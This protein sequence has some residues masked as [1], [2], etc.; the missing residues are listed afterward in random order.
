M[1]SSDPAI[2]PVADFQSNL[3]LL[4]VTSVRAS[5][6]VRERTIQYTHQEIPSSDHEDTFF[7]TVVKIVSCLRLVYM[8]WF[9]ML[10]PLL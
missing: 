6:R 3:M 9:A 5:E 4:R 2:A 8:L 7:A 1:I 10:T